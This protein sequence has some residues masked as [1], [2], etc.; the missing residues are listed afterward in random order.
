[1]ELRAAVGA[2]VDRLGL[3]HAQYSVLASLRGMTRAGH[4]PSQRELADYTG[5]DPIYISKL[6]RALESVGFVQR[7]ED[8]QDSRAVRLTITSRGG[9]VIDQA[10]P[11]VGGLLEELTASLGGTTSSRTRRLV[12][13]L[14]ALLA[15][16]PALHLSSPINRQKG[17][18]QSMSAPPL[19][20]S[21]DIGVTE[22]T[23]RA[24]LTKKLLRGT[25]LDYPQWVAFN[26]IASQPP[27]SATRLLSQM[28]AGLKIDQ[29]TAAKVIDQIETSGLITVVGDELR[30]TDDGRALHARVTPQLQALTQRMY[31][32]LDSDDLAAAYR[33]LST[34]T[35]RGNAILAEP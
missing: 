31:A 17:S 32:G 21:R 33:V 25:N 34:L 27:A 24:L 10:V 3:T 1:M 7:V 29:H 5:L 8:A 19:L 26:A 9:E 11:V 13:D 30:P 4:I 16:R 6:A 2:A 35:E 15:V 20:T 18:S 28:Q 12:S 22:N 23:L 14:E